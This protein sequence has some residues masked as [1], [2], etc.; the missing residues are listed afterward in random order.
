MKHCQR[1]VPVVCGVMKLILTVECGP[2]VQGESVQPA[3]LKSAVT[4]EAIGTNRCRL[5]MAKVW[6]TLQSDQV[7][8]TEAIWGGL[9]VWPTV[10]NCCTDI[11]LPMVP[12]TRLQKLLRAG[13]QPS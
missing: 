4:G 2:S 3:L 6:P 12:W 8:R 9:R 11:L 1:K 5:G 10:L 13:V 7:L